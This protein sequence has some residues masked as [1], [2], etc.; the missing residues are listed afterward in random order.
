M[1]IGQWQWHFNILIFDSSRP[2]ASSMLAPGVPEMMVELGSDDDS[3]KTFVVSIFVLGFALGPLI[4]AP[5]SE[6]YGRTPVYHVCN[7]MFLIWTIACGVATNIGM[8]LAFRFLAGFFGVAVLTCGSGT[9]IDLMPREKRGRAM[10]IW[11]VGPLL[12]PVIGPVCAGF[13]VEA[14]GYKWVF[15]V[16]AMVVSV[17]AL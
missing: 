15:W 11:S 13:L 7:S 6:L 12:G 9:I 10:S 2:L 1:A 3:A 5:M 17:F 4:T 14:M 16:I 8:M